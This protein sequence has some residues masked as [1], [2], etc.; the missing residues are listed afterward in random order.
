MTSSVET[1]NRRLAERL[2]RVCGG[3]IP[4]FSW[5]YAPDQPWLVYDRDERTVLKKS[6]ADMPAPDG[7]PIGKSWLLAEWRP[8]TAQDHHGFGEGVRVAVGK[9]VGY[10]P[11]L[12]TTLPAGCEPNDEVTAWMI[13]KIDRQLSVSAG[14]VGMSESMD[15]YMGEE[16]YSADRNQ[17]AFAKEHLE[18]SRHVYDNNVGAFGNCEVGVGDGFLSWGGVGDSPVVKKVQEAST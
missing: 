16:K 15:H 1:L 9:A 11:Y 5:Q 7:S 18:R 6:W 17:A 14:I 2:G 3:S 12:E 13:A 8:T 10:A 4:R